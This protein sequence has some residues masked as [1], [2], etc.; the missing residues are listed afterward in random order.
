M[1]NNTGIKKYL[2]L[3][4]ITLPLIS[5]MGPK[6]LQKKLNKDQYSLGYL[7][8]SQKT[9]NKTGI[10][11]SPEVIDL[12]DSASLTYVIKIDGYYIN[13]LFLYD[14]EYNFTV[15]LGKNSVK[16]SLVD[17]IKKS[18]IKESER[19]GAYVIN[20]TAADKSYT[21]AIGILEYKTECK[22]H[23]EGSGMGDN[24]EWKINVQPSQGKLK[25]LIKLLNSNNEIVFT[26]EYETEMLSDFLPPGSESENEINKNMMINMSETLSLCIKENISKIVSDMNEILLKKN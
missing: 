10:S 16:P 12:S 23:K 17:F 1:G 15:G 11:L 26:K 18:F 20:D 25:L 4:L 24:S 7:H 13:L 14:Y 22:Y 9:E 2:W 5:C 21:I 6:R 8:D 3:V 19:S